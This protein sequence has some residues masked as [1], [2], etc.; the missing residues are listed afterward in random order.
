MWLG[1]D[2]IGVVLPSD[3]PPVK[4]DKPSLSI[5]VGSNSTKF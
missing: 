1:L 3:T 5:S 2:L 4:P